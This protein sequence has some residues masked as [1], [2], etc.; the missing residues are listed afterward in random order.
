MHGRTVALCTLLLERDHHPP[1][2]VLFVHQIVCTN[3]QT[4]PC[5]R[6]SHGQ[7]H[8]LD[9]QQLDQQPAPQTNSFTTNQDQKRQQ[10]QLKA[11]C[12]PKGR[13]GQRLSCSIERRQHREKPHDH[14]RRFVL[15]RIQRFR[16]SVTCS[17]VSTRRDYA[18][19]AQL[20]LS[21]VYTRYSFCT[22]NFATK[23]HHLRILLCNPSIPFVSSQTSCLQV[24][25]TFLYYVSLSLFLRIVSTPEQALVLFFVLFI[26]VSISTLFVITLSV[27][28]VS[29]FLLFF[30]LF[31]VSVL[32]V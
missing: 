3:R 16:N 18:S 14:V 11:P 12:P 25:E 20:N 2:A 23:K 10:Q 32:L 8:V 24:Q 17:S 4:R 29:P 27:V 26:S 9:F 31:F 21:Q 6:V 13:I 28:Y 22:I 19:T 30:F 15:V 7:P 1:Q 5:R